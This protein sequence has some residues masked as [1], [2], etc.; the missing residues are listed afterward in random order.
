MYSIVTTTQFEKDIL[1]AKERKK[2]IS[3]F[4]F[5]LNLLE[6][7]KKLPNKY[8]NHKLK[9]VNP[10]TWDCHIT[11]DWILLYEIDKKQKII[12]LKRTGTHSDLF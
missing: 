7:G 12:K 4:A 8:K 5:V 11:P 2:D 10:Q 1:L 9:N 6:N 3:E